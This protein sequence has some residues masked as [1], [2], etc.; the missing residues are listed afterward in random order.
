[1]PGLVPGIHVLSISQD[2]DG[3]RNS[4]LPELRKNSYL[5]QVGY[6]RL[7]VTSPAMTQYVETSLI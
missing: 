1:M 6:T 3:T 2:V 5:P 4:G 7:A